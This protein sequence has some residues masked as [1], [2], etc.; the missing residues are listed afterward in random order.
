VLLE[1]YSVGSQGVEIG[2]AAAIDVTG[3][4]K[5][6]LAETLKLLEKGV[7]VMLVNASKP[8]RVAK[9]LEGEKVKGTLLTL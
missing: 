7:Q 3:G 1:S 5:G 6:K 2:G 8:G 4:M 9:A